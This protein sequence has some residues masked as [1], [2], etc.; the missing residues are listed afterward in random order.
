MLL[1]YCSVI[2][3]V[4]SDLF[5]YQKDGERRQKSA[6]DGK[7]NVMTA[8]VVSVDKISVTGVQSSTS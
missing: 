2:T 7:N 1:Q 8:K 4:T 3:L 5:S 6:K